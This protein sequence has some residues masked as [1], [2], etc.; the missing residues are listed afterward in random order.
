DPP[1]LEFLERAGDLLR[2][3][4][5]PEAVQF[6]HNFD[7]ISDGSP[8]LLDRSES[9]FEVGP[10]DVLTRGRLGSRV[11]WPDLHAADSLLDQ[12]L[13]QLVGAMQE[14][15]EVLVWIGDSVVLE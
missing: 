13:G 6:D 8:D 3:W 2:H 10:R 12:A 11:E 1:G 4:D 7:L 9:G 14:R 15:V 5:V